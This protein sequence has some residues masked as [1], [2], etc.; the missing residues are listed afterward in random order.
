MLFPSSW[1]ICIIYLN[2]QLFHFL[3]NF[4]SSWSATWI[5]SDRLVEWDRQRYFMR[6]VIPPK[7]IMQDK[8]IFTF[9]FEIIVL[10]T[11][12]NCS[13]TMSWI[14]Y[15][16]FTWF[17]RTTSLIHLAEIKYHMY[18]QQSTLMTYELKSKLNKRLLTFNF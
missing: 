16:K 6:L 7:W 9:Y 18:Q 10:V 15:F 5:K 1:F 8:I 2:L 4:C 13:A 11:S 3:I 14:S 12:S 17:A